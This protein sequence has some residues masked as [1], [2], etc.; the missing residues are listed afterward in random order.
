MVNIRTMSI[1]VTEG[2]LDIVSGY[3]LTFRIKYGFML[4]DVLFCYTL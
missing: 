2:C 1:S 3:F 4:E